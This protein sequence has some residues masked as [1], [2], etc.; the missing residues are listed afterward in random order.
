MFPTDSILLRVF[1][2][3]LIVN[4]NGENIDVSGGT[5]FVIEVD[6][7]QY[8]V[9]ARHIAEHIDSHVQVR[10]GITK[11]GTPFRLE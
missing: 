11:D 10:F 4:N 9:T 6:N 2:I 8:L 5:M 7:R 3:R 1:K